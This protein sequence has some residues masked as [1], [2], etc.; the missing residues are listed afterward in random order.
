[1][2]RRA[3]QSLGRSPVVGEK[4][5]VGAVGLQMGALDPQQGVIDLQ[6]ESYSGE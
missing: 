2:A 5:Q 3:E 1:M 6:Q 4:W